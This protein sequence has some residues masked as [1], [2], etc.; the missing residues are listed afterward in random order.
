MSDLALMEMAQK[1]AEY[2]YAPYSSFAVGAALLCK[3]GTVFSGCN[4]ENAAF[5][6]TV[7]AER[8]A[9][10]K[11]ISE[12][13]HDFAAIAVA[14]KKDGVWVDAVSPCGVCR[15]V[16]AEFCDPDTFRILTLSPD[17]IKSYTLTT[18]LPHGFGKSDLSE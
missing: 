16:L 4:V 14:A 6:P 3:D 18:L 13:Q 15:Q 1:A 11:A 8:T 9:V 12:G 7:C 5:S 17:G 10:V 2:A